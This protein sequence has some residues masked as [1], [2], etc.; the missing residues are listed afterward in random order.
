M[1]DGEPIAVGTAEPVQPLIQE[2]RLARMQA[3]EAVQRIQRRIERLAHLSEA[4]DRLRCGDDAR[5]GEL[6][7][8][9]CRSD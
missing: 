7:L 5:E 4:S 6:A 9:T 8:T 3:E 2:A 1:M